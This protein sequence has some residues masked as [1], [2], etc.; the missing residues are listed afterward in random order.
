MPDIKTRDG[1][2]KKKIKV[3]D[4]TIIVSEKTKESLVNI[5][6]KYSSLENKEQSENEYAS[7]RITKSSEYVSNKVIDHS[8]QVLKNQKNKVIKN[9][10][11]KRISKVKVKRKSK[12]LKIK[13]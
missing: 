6:N 1:F 9:I 8:R 2:N 10:N 3:L 7:N 11:R 13:V 4:K 12:S 5:K